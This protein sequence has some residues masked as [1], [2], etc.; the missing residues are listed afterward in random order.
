V[1]ALGALFV[2]IRWACRTPV[3]QI[4]AT[5][6]STVLRWYQDRAG[7]CCR[8]WLLSLSL[9]FYRGVMLA[10]ALWVAQAL[11]GWLRGAAAATGG[12]WLRR[13]P[14]AYAPSDPPLP[15]VALRSLSTV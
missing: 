5:A 2:A 6:P 14:L 3:M 4:M 10:W 11:V 7:A 8:P 9:W 12:Y 1:V 15:V 13:Q